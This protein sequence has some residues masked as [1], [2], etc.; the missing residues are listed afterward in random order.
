[1]TQPSSTESGR[2]V[3]WRLGL[4]VMAGWLVIGLISSGLT[5]STWQSEGL[6]I[7][8][9]LAYVLLLPYWLF[10]GVVTPI[11]I[12]LGRRFPIN[13][14]RWRKSVAIHFTACLVLGVVHFIGYAA[15]Y[16]TFFP[17]PAN[18]P[19]GPP[20]ST[21]LLMML[22]SRWQFEFMAYGGI[23]GCSL[24]ITYARESEARA[25]AAAELE[26]QLAQ[27]QLASL[28]MQL[29]PHFLFN[30]LQS[31]SVLVEEDPRRAR[32]MLVL[33]GDLLRSVLEGPG[34]Q[35]VPLAQ[36]LDLL[37]RYLEIE[38]TRFSDRLNVRIE[39]D[40]PA[41]TL[42]VPSL[43]LQPL[44]E[45]AVRYAIAPKATPGTIVVRA[46][47]ADHRLTLTVSDDGPGLPRGFVERVG[48]ATTRARLEKL[49]GAAQSFTLEPGFAGGTIATIVL[50]ARK[51]DG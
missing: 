5:Y 20:W 13:R 35:E 32:R 44:V 24:A 41:R 19:G 21:L 48:L 26:A 31:V 12:A 14:E 27:A 16:K 37:E 33:L 47:T 34:R 42:L 17:W 15:F 23:L 46:A 10:W 22:S 3:N 28:R 36:E 49:Y 7:D 18:E 38:Q 39:V 2:A 9:P 8:W 45:N 30:T 50:P 29:N 11:I 6:K 43:L 4:G 40:P 1:M 25:L 51:A